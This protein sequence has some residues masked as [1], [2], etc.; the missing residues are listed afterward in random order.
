MKRALLIL[1][2]LAVALAAVSCTDKNGTLNALEA[3]GYKSV[4]LTGWDMF[5]CSKDD[6]TCTGFRAVAPSGKV[7]TGAVGCGL[8]FKGCTIR[9]K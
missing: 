3:N 2:A 1:A 7:V 9:L 4:H 5:T 6:S 8:L